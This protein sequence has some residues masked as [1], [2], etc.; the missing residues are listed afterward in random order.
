MPP[1]SKKTDL[2]ALIRQMSK[3]WKEM[4]FGLGIMISVWSWIIGKIDVE[5]MFGLWLPL[6]TLYLMLINK[7][8]DESS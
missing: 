4:I 7:R 5:K 8:K 6:G 3:N 1:K 2:I